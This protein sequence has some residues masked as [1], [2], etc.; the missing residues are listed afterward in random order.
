MISRCGLPLPLVV[1]VLWSC[2]EDDRDVSRAT[3]KAARREVRL[4]SKSGLE[5]EEPGESSGW[6]EVGWAK[7]AWL[8]RRMRAVGT[9]KERW[10]LFEEEEV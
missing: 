3:R 2:P 9:E 1:V 7:A 6:S 10:E 4:I 5:R 8:S